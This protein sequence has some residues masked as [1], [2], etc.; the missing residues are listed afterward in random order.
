MSEN[1]SEGN[2]IE[3]NLLSSS[4]EEMTDKPLIPEHATTDAS[5]TSSGDTTKEH[6]TQRKRSMSED[7]QTYNPG[8]SSSVDSLIH[9]KDDSLLS[10]N[11]QITPTRQD[12]NCNQLQLQIDWESIEKLLVQPADSDEYNPTRKRMYI[13]PDNDSN[14]A[15]YGTKTCSPVSNRSDHGHIKKFRNEQISEGSSHES[16]D[17]ERENILPSSETRTIPKNEIHIDVSDKSKKNKTGSVCGDV[18]PDCSGNSAT[19]DD[20]H[21]FK[22]PMKDAPHRN[23]SKLKRTADT[24]RDIYQR[25]PLPSSSKIYKELAYPKVERD[26]VNINNFNPEN[27]FYMQLL[28]SKLEHLIILINEKIVPNIEEPAELLCDLLESQQKYLSKFSKEKSSISVACQTNEIPSLT[29]HQDETRANSHHTLPL[30]SANTSRNITNNSTTGDRQNN[31]SSKLVS[32]NTH[33]DPAVNKN[34]SLEGSLH[35]MHNLPERV[36]GTIPFG[37]AKPDNLKLGTKQSALTA[38]MMPGAFTTEKELMPGALIGGMIPQTFIPV[39]TAGGYLAGIVSGALMPGSENNYPSVKR[40]KCDNSGTASTSVV[41]G[42]DMLSS[43]SIIRGTTERTSNIPT[44]GTT[45]DGNT[46]GVPVVESSARTSTASGMVTT[47]ATSATGTIEATSYSRSITDASDSRENS[48]ISVSN[49]S[50]STS[51]SQP[52]PG[53]SG[54][55]AKPGTSGGEAKQGTSGWVPQPSTS[56]WEPQRGTSVWK[57]LTSTPGR[58]ARPGTSGWVPI[59]S[60]SGWVP[61]PGISGMGSKGDISNKTDVLIPPTLRALLTGPIG[62]MAEMVKN[63]TDDE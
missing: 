50:P 10:K 55:E 57:P 22:R 51:V 47:Q 44:V 48:S 7:T 4:N 17:G 19:K 36:A 38:G 15:S 2:N 20:A 3:N 63:L 62:S 49:T 12:S 33:K 24:S 54:R 46:S 40:V 21:I 52:K 56:G 32:P 28:L 34:N 60:T 53:P 16:S 9:S 35:S 18:I 31:L 11:T 61:K 27:S 14:S 13:K 8:H 58:E 1:K 41:S 37:G 5:N 26:N 45:V 30:I 59:P 23:K 29:S 42:M 6:C 25:V 43:T 39:F